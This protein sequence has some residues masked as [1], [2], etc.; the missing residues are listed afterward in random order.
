MTRND[1]SEPVTRQADTRPKGE[2]V[3]HRMRYECGCLFDAATWRD[4][5][6]TGLLA[7]RSVMTCPQHGRIWVSGDT[8]PREAA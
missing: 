3:W 2:A 4:E 8:R 7:E 6:F 1:Q 5:E